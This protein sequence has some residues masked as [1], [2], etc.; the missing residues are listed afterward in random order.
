MLYDR[1]HER[2]GAKYTKEGRTSLWQIHKTLPVKMEA[3]GLAGIN[4][5]QG[6]Q[7]YHNNP[8]LRS[9]TEPGLLRLRVS[10]AN[11]A[12]RVAG[13]S[14]VHLLDL[15]LIRRRAIHRSPPQDRLPQ[16]RPAQD[17]GNRALVGLPPEVISRCQVSRRAFSAISRRKTRTHHS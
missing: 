1:K 3:S 13:R 10:F 7:E 5:L 9:L 4:R 16:A 6:S 15:R 11:L 14:S 2:S 12:R 8:R 17:S